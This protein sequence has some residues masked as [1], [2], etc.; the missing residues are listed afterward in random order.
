MI[1]EPNESDRHI[2]SMNLYQ[3]EEKNFYQNKLSVRNIGNF[4]MFKPSY[5]PRIIKT[6]TLKNNFDKNQSSIKYIRKKRNFTEHN[7]YIEKT[8]NGNDSASL[9][10]IAVKKFKY[11]SI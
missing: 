2:S 3:E 5:S 11:L 8:D 7:K 9:M 1:L 4:R 6:N 10:N